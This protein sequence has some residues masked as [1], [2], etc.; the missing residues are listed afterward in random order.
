MEQDI[1]D[2]KSSMVLEDNHLFIHRCL[3]RVDYVL[4]YMQGLAQ[5]TIVQVLCMHENNTQPGLWKL[6]YWWVNTCLKRWWV[7][8]KRKQCKGVDNELWDCDSEQKGWWEFPCGNGIE[9]GSWWC[10]TRNTKHMRGDHSNWGNN[11]YSYPDTC[12]HL[13]Y[14]RDSWNPVARTSWATTRTRDKSGPRKDLESCCL[15]PCT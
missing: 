2:V 4:C 6:S 3:M 8:W 7:W 9:I 11:M 5:R 15:W 10:K 14:L 12:V 13:I 1:Y